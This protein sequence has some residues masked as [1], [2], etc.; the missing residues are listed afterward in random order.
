MKQLFVFLFLLTFFTPV[1]G[2]KLSLKENAMVCNRIVKVSDLVFEETDKELG[3]IVVLELKNDYYK[4]KNN[5]L[6]SKLILNGYKD[7]IISGKESIIV[8]EDNE[9]EQ[10]N[11]ILDIEENNNSITFLRDYLTSIIDKDNFKIN[12]NILKTEPKIELEEVKE[13]YN[14]ELDKFK[15]GLKDI[16]ELKKCIIVVDKKK[17]YVTLDINI[18]TD[19]YISKK[20][21]LENDFFNKDNFIKKYLDISIFK[22]SDQLVFDIEKACNSKF[23]KE[24]GTG[25]ALKWSYI[26]KIPLIVKDEEIKMKIERNN[27][28]IQIKCTALQDGYENEKIKVKLINGKE[29]IGILKKINGENYVEI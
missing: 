24:I 22:D 15:N 12:I 9:S 28:M 5:E 6:L 27:I 17:Y 16:I 18:Y 8:Y 2:L 23:I 19:I 21:F 10:T 14:W 13:N 1:F 4:L 7:I 3:S 11:D 25:E 26:K 29:K 20:S